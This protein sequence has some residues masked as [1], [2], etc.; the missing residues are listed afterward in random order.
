[1]MPSPQDDAAA[2]NTAHASKSFLVPLFFQKSGE[3]FTED[4]L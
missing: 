4:A 2:A 3:S 1:M